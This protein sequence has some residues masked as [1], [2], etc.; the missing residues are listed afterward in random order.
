LQYEKYLLSWKIRNCD[1]E[2]SRLN[3][4]YDFFEA[5]QPGSVCEG[6]KEMVNIDYNSQLQNILD[7][8]LM[9][10]QVSFEKFD[11]QCGNLVEKANECEKKL[12][13]IEMK[14]HA[15]LVQAE[16]L[17]NKSR[18]IEEKPRVRSVDLYLKMETQSMR[19]KENIHLQ[20]KTHSSIWWDATF[21]RSILVGA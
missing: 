20:E 17:K 7:D 9:S 3:T 1:D 15:L 14:R 12:V 4:R 16:H 19:M 11:V 10:N 8:F 21:S 18:N 2:I 6:K 5:N 13:K